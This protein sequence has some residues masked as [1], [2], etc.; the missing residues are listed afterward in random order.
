M[1]DK[2]WKQKLQDKMAHYEEP[3]PDGLW[4]SIERQLPVAEPPVQGS[5]KHIISL[6]VGRLAAAAACIAFVL[7]IGKEW[8]NTPQQPSP[9]A[10]E[11]LSTITATTP[12][13]TEDNLMEEVPQQRAADPVRQVPIGRSLKASATHLPEAEAEVTEVADNL[14]SHNVDEVRQD[15]EQ[16]PQPEPP[17]RAS[18]PTERKGQ[19]SGNAWTW[20]SPTQRHK[21][22]EGSRLTASLYASGGPVDALSQR[23]YDLGFTPI[24]AYAP[25]TSNASYANAAYDDASGQQITASNGLAE[26]SAM[27]RS[28]SNNLL[29]NSTYTEYRHEVKHHLPLRGGINLRYALTDRLAIESGLS[30]TRMTSDFY[31]GSPVNYFST[32]QTLHYIGVPVHLL[33]TVWRPS[34]LEIYVIGGVMVEKNKKGDS[35]TTYQINQTEVTHSTQHFTEKRLLWSANGG[36]GVQYNL[37]HL[38]GIYAEPSVSYYFDNGSSVSNYY[39][40]KPL[41]FNLK[42][43]LRYSFNR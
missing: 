13:T 32:T 26:N 20:N 5:G 9:T 36:V 2:N 34:A 31:E 40:D 1:K 23:T 7:L 19:V 11:T 24:Y 30:Y 25:K 6:W 4:E 17:S 18:E 43:G 8:M 29:L 3:A 10:T 28:V 37:N 42:V 12:V 21:K 38:F 35:D 41:E 14:V 22:Q 16:E 15:S 39:K 33:Y 27:V